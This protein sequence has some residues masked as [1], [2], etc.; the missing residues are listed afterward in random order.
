M[1]LSALPNE[2]FPFVVETIT[3]VTTAHE[4]RNYFRVEARLERISHRLRP[5]MEGVG[6]VLV[7]RR[8]L[9][10]IWTRDLLEGLRLWLW[11]WLP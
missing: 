11:T 2:S 5:G 7:D 1:V 6:K 3:P 10:D 9:I 4:G 8:K